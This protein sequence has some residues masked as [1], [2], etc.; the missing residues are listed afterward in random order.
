MKNIFTVKSLLL[1]FI[2]INVSFKGSAQISGVPANWKLII[3][4]V[5][6]L[7]PLTLFRKSFHT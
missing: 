2:F 1:I 7:N 5:K 4:M 6:Q 3:E